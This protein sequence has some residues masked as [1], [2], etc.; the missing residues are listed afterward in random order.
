MDFESLESRELGCW[1]GPLATSALVAKSADF[2]PHDDFE[3]GSGY[4]EFL[5]DIGFGKNVTAD[6]TQ[7]WANSIQKIYSGDVG[8][9]LIC[10]AAVCL[11]SR[12]GLYAR[13]SH[14]RCPVLW[15]QVC[16][17][18]LPTNRSEMASDKFREPMTL[19]SVSP[20]QKRRLR[21]LPILLKQN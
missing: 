17:L 16:Y 3:P 13:L 2:T 6:I 10:M 11:A 20:M 8:K 7:I 5:M 21:C 14:I 19:S 1:N 15:M 9:R 12:D 18:N 4:V